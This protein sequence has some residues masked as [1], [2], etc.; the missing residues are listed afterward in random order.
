MKL[1]LLGN[2]GAGKS[3][4]ARRLMGG[5]DIPR[6]SLDEIAWDEGPTRKPLAESIALLEDFVARHPEW[7][8]EGC[9]GDLIAAALP[10]CEELRF[11]NPGVEVCVAHCL[12]RPWEPEKFPSPEAQRATLDYL[13]GWVRAYETRDDEY[14]LTRHRALYDTFKGPKRE[15]RTPADYD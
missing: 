8:I 9:Y 3:T 10:H 5:R 12:A 15:Y 1:V 2:A 11:L 4:L 6:L 7:I 14:G 13:V